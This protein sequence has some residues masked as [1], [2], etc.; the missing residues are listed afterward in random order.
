MSRIRLLVLGVLAVGVVFAV[1]AASASAVVF[2]LEITEC[3]GSTTTTICWAEKTTSELL[4]LK[5]EQSF[6]GTYSAEVTGEE[7]L[8]A[9]LFGTEEVHITCTG[10]TS[11]GTVLQKNPLVEGPVVDATSLIS[12]GCKVLEP[13][14][15]KCKVEEE[16]VTK[17]IEGVVGASPEEVLFQPTPAD[18]GIF[19]TITFANNTETCPAAIVGPQN[20]KG[21]QLCLWPHHAEDLATQLLFCE[22]AGSKL[23]LGGNTAEF[24]QAQEI[25]FV[26]LNNF[27]DI[28]LA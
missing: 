10:A 24:L 4:E 13:I 8:L 14:A 7:N 26:G 9:A 23:T 6:T 21:S 27:V 5:G 22:T 17:P 3:T 20:V 28:V 25:T 2:S 1:A 15:K 16:L 11:S 19:I 12:T 18:K